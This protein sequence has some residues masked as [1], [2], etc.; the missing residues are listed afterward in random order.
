MVKSMNQ[1]Q[2]EEYVNDFIDA[3][4]ME[5]KPVPPPSMNQ[6]LAALLET[7][8]SVKRL[9]SEKELLPE[10]RSDTIISKGLERTEISAVNR[11]KN[12]GFQGWM[13]WA[14]IAA[15]LFLMVGVISQMQRV[16]PAMDAGDQATA[17]LADEVE[18]AP[19]MMR[20]MEI[21][22]AGEEVPEEPAADQSPDEAPMIMGAREQE[23]NPPVQSA[24]TADE[25]EI[26]IAGEALTENDGMSVFGMDSD[27]FQ[28]GL[29]VY[30]RQIDNTYVELRLIDVPAPFQEFKLA[31]E[32]KKELENQN[33]Q[34]GTL[35]SVSFEGDEGE[36]PVLTMMA[37]VDQFSLHAQYMGRVD[38]NFGEFNINGRLLVMAL[39][40]EVTSIFEKYDDQLKDYPGG[41]PVAIVIEAADYS[42]SGMVTAVEK[43]SE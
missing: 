33:L 23:E 18:E 9:R 43:I 35:F 24:H 12:R 30:V 41:V 26:I 22:G 13:K 16:Q 39:S 11:Q 5:C 40:E 27:I 36:I 15:A 17:A 42:T 10:T 6:D 20:S 2:Q 8:R 38:S 14:S 34:P 31:D 32:L 21:A 7:V 1:Q 28:A 25:E 29:A 19:E 4:I 37:A 3:L